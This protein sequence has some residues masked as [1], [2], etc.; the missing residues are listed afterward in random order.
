[1]KSF[2]HK[3]LAWG[4]ILAALPL[5]T[6]ATTGYFQHGYGVKSRGVA[7][8]G[9]AFPQDA[10]DAAINP[11]NMVFVGDDQQLGIGI[12]A[13]TRKYTVSGQPSGA[14]GTFGLFPGT[15]KSENDAFLIPNYARNW[16][17][18]EDS[19]IGLTVYANGG[20]NT[21]W[22]DTDVDPFGF[23]TYGGGTAGV[24]YSQLFASTTYARK[25]APGAA[26]NDTFWNNKRMGE[27]LSLSLAETDPAKRHAYYCEM[28]TLIH[29]GSGMV[30]PAFANI[31]DGTSVN[32]M[33][34][35]TV[36]LGSNGAAEWPE[37]IWLA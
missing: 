30:I 4:I 16:M 8:A 18:N 33:G 29:E 14:P 25:F 13:P 15:V 22:K 3:R 21:E 37:F 10:M 23:G 7:G 35:P 20:M 31:T 32:V 24:D 5:T 9:V 34:M 36:P 27:L 26:W 19:S 12:F 11:A 6:L 1:M 17:L 28:Q 2:A